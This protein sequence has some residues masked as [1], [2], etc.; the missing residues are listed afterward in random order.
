MSNPS[1]P[2]TGKPPRVKMIMRGP[3]HTITETHWFT[4][5]GQLGAAMAEAKNLASVRNK[6][7]GNDADVLI[8]VG[9][10]DNVLGDS[11]ADDSAFQLAR[12]AG[13]GASDPAQTNLLIRCQSG[14]LSRRSLYLGLIPDLVVRGGKYDPAQSVRFDNSLKT[15]LEYLAPTGPGDIPLW[16]F[17][18]VSRDPILFPQ[19]P[20][21]A[22]S[23]DATASFLT[24]HTAAPGP[25]VVG[26]VVRI[27]QITDTVGK[28]PG[29]GGLYVLSTVAGTDLTVSGL[30]KANLTG[31]VVSGTIMKQEKRFQGYQQCIN[32]GI[33]GHK[34]GNRALQPLGRRKKMR[35]VAI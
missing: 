5:D 29:L 2:I 26:D 20:L 14:P 15:Y 10:L 27:S 12:N 22:Y 31:L 7:L 18:G 19:V 30:F 24:V 9:S 6:L 28:V 11:L 33:S 17:L 23:T 16:G 3:K 32:R 35:Q 34:R 4:S 13:Y 21:I 1:I 25:F 8:V